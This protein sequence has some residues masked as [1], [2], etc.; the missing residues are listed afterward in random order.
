MTSNDLYTIVAIISLIFLTT[1]A[2]LALY[3]LILIL[4]RIHRTM[5]TFHEH[6]QGVS[7]GVQDMCR[8]IAAVKDS[9]EMITKTFATI[10]ALYKKQA[11]KKGKSAKGESASGGKN[12]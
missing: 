4:K 5:D 10:V 6:V 9:A 8:K 11:E 3:Y 1:F 2:C 7:H 12:Q